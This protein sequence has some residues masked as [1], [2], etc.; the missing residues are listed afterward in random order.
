MSSFLSFVIVILLRSRVGSLLQ[1]ESLAVDFRF[2][3]L[4]FLLAAWR[5]GPV[6]QETQLVCLLNS[7]NVLSF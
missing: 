1:I 7:E 6:S 4:K 2:V 5:C 3:R